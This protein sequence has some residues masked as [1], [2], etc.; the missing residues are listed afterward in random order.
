MGGDLTVR[1]EVGLGTAFT[2][3]I[4]IRCAVPEAI[5]AHSSSRRA[6]GLASGQP[7]YR[8]LAVDDKPNNRRLLVTLLSSL[9]FQ[10]HEA[11]NGLEAIATW[12]NWVPHL[13]LMDMRMPEMD[14]YEATRRI[15]A[16]PQGRSTAII[17]LTAS[18][19]QEERHE[20]IEAGCDDCVY[21]P[22]REEDLIAA[23]V[24]HLHI[25][26]VY[27]D[28]VVAPKNP[29][30]NSGEALTAAALAAIMDVD[31]INALQTAARSGDDDPIYPLIGQ[32]PPE[33][34]PLIEG[35]LQLTEQFAFDQILNLTH[36]PSDALR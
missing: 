21:K 19:L 31:W 26:F 17:A 5:S 11:T 24:K 33:H 32:I 6:I 4:L 23:L 18:A 34:T 9:G 35:L 25:E 28:P 2:F 14:G 29:A 30:S 13:I 16:T 3:A 7:S 20:M 1:S 36:S 8:I 15:K 10:V 12:E 27:D 22:F